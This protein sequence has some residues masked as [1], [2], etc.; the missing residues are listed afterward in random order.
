MSDDALDRQGVIALRPHPRYR[1]FL[2]GMDGQILREKTIRAAND[3]EAVS[4][5]VGMMDGRP[6][7]LWDGLR[8]IRHFPARDDSQTHFDDA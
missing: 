5:A 6:I 4:I 8:F 3:D 7:D 2:L 1:V